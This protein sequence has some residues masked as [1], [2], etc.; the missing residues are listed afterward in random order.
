MISEKRQIKTCTLCAVLDLLGGERAFKA[1]AIY[2]VKLF[3]D[4]LAYLLWAGSVFQGGLPFK[5]K[6]DYPVLIGG[7]C[8]PKFEPVAA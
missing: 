1:F 3:L 7:A 4:L 5:P 8:P 2:S 6:I